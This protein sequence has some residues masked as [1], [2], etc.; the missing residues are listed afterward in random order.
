M[1]G[2]IKNVRAIEGFAFIAGEDGIDRFV[3]HSACVGMTLS[4]T[5]V[6]LYV[7]FE[8][9]MAARG[10]RAVNVTLVSHTPAAGIPLGTLPNLGLVSGTS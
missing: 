10:P 8:P 5:L 1:I 3:H 9:A 2:R 7:E 6:G 4:D